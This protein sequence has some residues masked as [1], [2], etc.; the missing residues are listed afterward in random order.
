MSVQIDPRYFF[1]DPSVPLTLISA[2]VEQQYLHYVRYQ[3]HHA[4]GVCEVASVVM[5]VRM[6]PIYA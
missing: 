6:W 4:A 5:G 3:L 1:L 2:G